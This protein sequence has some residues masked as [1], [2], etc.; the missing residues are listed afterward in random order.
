MSAAKSGTAETMTVL[1]HA[2]MY[3]RQ[4]PGYDAETRRYPLEVPTRDVSPSGLLCITRE[5]HR[6]VDVTHVPTGLRVPMIG[7]DPS[8]EDRAAGKTWQRVTLGDAESDP[9]AFRTVTAARAAMLALDGAGVDLTPD[10]TASE[11]TREMVRNI[12]AAIDKIGANR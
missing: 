2:T 7:T 8:E 4:R 6:V 12:R 11:Q 5:R 10:D 9:G 1:M 3:D